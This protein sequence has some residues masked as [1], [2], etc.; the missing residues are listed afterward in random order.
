M[1]PTLTKRQAEIF[2]FVR[3]RIRGGK[4][5]TVREVS[6]RFKMRSPSGAAYQLNAIERKGFIK[7]ERGLCRSITITLPRTASEINAE[8]ARLQH[9]LATITAGI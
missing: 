4:P 8:I 2:D 6:K 5:P 3:S 7:R 1:Q 9:E